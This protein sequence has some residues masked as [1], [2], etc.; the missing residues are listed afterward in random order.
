MI[1]DAVIL[2]E[3]SDPSFKCPACLDIFKVSQAFAVGCVHAHRFCADDIKRHAESRLRSNEIPSCPMC[4]TTTY[5]FS[6]AEIAMLFGRGQLHSRFLDISV[7][8]VL[9]N[10]S[11][12]V[13]CPTPDCKEYLVLNG[14]SRQR[15]DC[16]SCKAIFCSECRDLF[17]HSISCSEV[18]VAAARWLRW[19]A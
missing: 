10:S 12:V 7:R 17:H 16:P 19:Q 14:S 18:K 11:D 1:P 3:A 9:V 5:Q 6:E 13:A 4:T 2:H 15:V 8:D